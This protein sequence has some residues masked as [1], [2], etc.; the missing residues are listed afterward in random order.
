MPEKARAVLHEVVSVPKT[1][2]GWAMRV[3][4]IAV[5]LCMIS[6]WATFAAS[7]TLSLQIEELQEKNGT[8]QKQAQVR[9]CLLLQKLGST[10]EEL[11][12]VGCTP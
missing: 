4:T 5:V 1:F 9:G 12:S 3:L 11:A 8:Y 7:R 2:D 10:P 6:A